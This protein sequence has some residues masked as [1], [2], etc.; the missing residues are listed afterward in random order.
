MKL[1]VII[2]CHNEEENVYKMYKTCSDELK[3]ID[4]ELIFVNDGS[5]DQTFLSIK[6]AYDEDNNHVKGIN[7]SRNFG[8]EAAIY[9]GLVNS[10][11]EYTAI[12][13][14]D[15]QQ[16]PK[17]LVTM[18]EYLDKN[19][20]TDQ[21]AMYIRKRKNEGLKSALS[22]K[23]YKMINKISDIKFKGNASDFRMFRK[24]VKNAVLDMSEVN[25]FSKGIFSWVG[26]NTHYM[27]YEVLDRKY[28]KSSFNMKSLFKYAID[29]I[30]GFSVKP[31][32]FAT[33]L[34]LIT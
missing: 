3:N 6:K 2:P 30:V 23:F 24:N 15:L 28:G 13:D 18:L 7:F 27:P 4:Y 33:Y 1:S 21:V 29:G 14:G 11:G 8:K 12:I 9:A 20:D 16:H 34:G 5:K 25:R 22:S 17:Y 26:F 19:K 32:A 10:K 31:L